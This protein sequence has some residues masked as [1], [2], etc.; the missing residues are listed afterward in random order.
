MV[1]PCEGADVRPTVRGARVLDE[2]ART[3]APSHVRTHVRTLAPSHRRTYSDVGISCSDG[4]L[5]IAPTRVQLIAAA[6]LAKRTTSRGV[7]PRSN[8]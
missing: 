1:R 3:F 4:T 8:A 5:L 6:T 2:R 7:S